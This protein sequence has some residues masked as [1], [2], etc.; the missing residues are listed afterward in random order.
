MP[1]STS[2]SSVSLFCQG[3]SVQASDYDHQIFFYLLTIVGQLHQRLIQPYLLMPLRLAALIDES[4]REEERLNL[5]NDLLGKNNCCIEK[6]FARPV[7]LAMQEEGGANSILPPHSLH[8]DLKTAFAMK[9]TTVET[10]LSFSRAANMRQ[11]MRGRRHGIGAMASK[12]VGA[13]VKLAQKRKIMADSATSSALCQPIER[14]SKNKNNAEKGPGRYNGFS[15]FLKDFYS[16]TQLPKGGP[17]DSENEDHWFT[18]RKHMFHE[19]LESWRA[20]DETAK[21]QF[22]AR[23]FELNS[24]LKRK[25]EESQVLRDEKEHEAKERSKAIEQRQVTIAS[26]ALQHG[27][28][29]PDSDAYEPMPSQMRPHALAAHAEKFQVSPLPLPAASGLEGAGTMVLSEQGLGANLDSNQAIDKMRPIMDNKAVGEAWDFLLNHGPG[30]H[31]LGDAEFG[32]S[33]ALLNHVIE[34]APGFVSRGSAEF[35]KS[36]GNLCQKTQKDFDGD[37][38]DED[39]VEYP[40]T[41]GHLV[42]RYCVKDIQN[43]QIFAHALEMNKSIART[44][45][46]MRVVQVGK[47]KHLCPTP[48]TYYPVLVMTD[49][50]ANAIH[51]RI[52]YRVSFSPLECDFIHCNV[53][54]NN[55]DLYLQLEVDF[56]PGS[57]KCLGFCTDQ[58]GEFAT[59]FSMNYNPEWT[60]KLYLEYDIVSISGDPHLVLRPDH[61][62]SDAGA[63]G[64]ASFADCVPVTERAAPITSDERALASV[65]NLLDSVTSFPKLKKKRQQQKQQRPPVSALSKIAKL[66][67]TK[68]VKDLA[69]ADRA[70]TAKLVVSLQ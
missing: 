68:D 29:F 2:S 62:V 35:C 49:H 50:K 12:H 17:K 70:S 24:Q 57:Q 66:K 18:K 31:G 33:K 55:G 63:V 52:V 8:Y 30:L 45:S 51:A 10:E 32:I 39:D 59:W 48:E 1:G 19:A 22:A 43:P 56:L 65:T 23:A 15:V 4:R 60:C 3:L 28:I 40:R 16:Q 44:I 69:A 42:G 7:L 5:A 11:A 41:C 9:N 6:H 64:E 36:H 61:R 13:E 38:G 27:V 46:K 53:R 58:A 20:V 37:L 54:K 34:H 26:A 21:L 14:K 47:Q 25:H 67:G